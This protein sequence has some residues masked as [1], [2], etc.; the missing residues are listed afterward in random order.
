MADTF[1]PLAGRSPTA[2]ARQLYD[3]M[4]GARDGRNAAAMKSVV[5]NLTDQD[6]VD[7]TAYIASLQP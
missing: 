3:F 4:S 1:P 6:I 7:L 2:T 5:A